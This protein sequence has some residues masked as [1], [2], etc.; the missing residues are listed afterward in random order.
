MIA[1]FD[2][3]EWSYQADDEKLLVRAGIKGRACSFEFVAFIDEHDEVFQVI[4]L[5]PVAIPEGCRSAVAETVARI[6]YGLKI[7]NFEFEYDEGRLRYRV[8]QILVDGRLEDGTI[9]HAIG[10]CVSLVNR[11]LPA[12]LSV[13]YGN[14]LPKDA[15]RCAEA[16]LVR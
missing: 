1:H 15:I 4:A 12:V 16:D 6:N 11:Y 9:H 3:N 8:G 13:I 14:E 10:C 5:V 7:G 2:R